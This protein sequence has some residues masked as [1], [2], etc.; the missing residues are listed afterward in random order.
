MVFCCGS[1]LGGRLRGKTCSRR[2]GGFSL[3]HPRREILRRMSD[4]MIDLSAA[5]NLLRP[6]AKDL[7]TDPPRLLRVFDLLDAEEGRL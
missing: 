6:L 7:R 4:M 2:H 3:Q 5:A 1:G